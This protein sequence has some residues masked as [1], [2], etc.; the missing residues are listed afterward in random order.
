[1]KVEKILGTKYEHGWLKYRIKW[2]G[3]E[4]TTW[5]VEANLAGCR[6]VLRKFKM[7]NGI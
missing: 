7:A 1:M 5:E 2:L 3:Y 4:D 6:D